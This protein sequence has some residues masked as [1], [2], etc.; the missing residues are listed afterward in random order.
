[1]GEQYDRATRQ[2][3]AVQDTTC[4]RNELLCHIFNKYPYDTIYSAVSEFYENE[5]VEDAKQLLW[6]SHSSH[7]G[8][9]PQHKG[10]KDKEKILEILCRH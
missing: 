6:Q 4:V 9:Y 2:S 8:T 3:V 7:L 10:K 1:M 5:S